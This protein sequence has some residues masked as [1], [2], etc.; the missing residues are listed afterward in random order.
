MQSLANIAWAFA[1]LRYYDTK[2]FDAIAHQTFALANRLTD[3]DVAHL[4]WAICHALAAQAAAE[5]TG[6]PYTT[7][8]IMAALS[9]DTSNIDAAYYVSNCWTVRV[10]CILPVTPVDV[11]HSVPG[12]HL[13]RDT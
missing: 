3:K 13:T 11:L 8:T 2:L 7:P 9:G 6:R 5:G 4:T 1:K 12:F 10:P